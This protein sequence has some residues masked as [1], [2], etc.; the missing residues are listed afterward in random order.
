MNMW[1]AGVNWWGGN[2]TLTQ[3]RL[4]HRVQDWVRNGSKKM[5]VI[6]MW[7][8]LSSINVT[9]NAWRSV[10]CVGVNCGIDGDWW[11]LMRSG[12]KNNVRVYRT[13]I[14]DAPGSEVTVFEPNELP[15][16]LWKAGKKGRRQPIFFKNCDLWFDLTHWIQSIF[17]VI[18]LSTLA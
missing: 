13:F 5:I 8:S 15:W 14:H 7:L 4:D 3:M 1:N 10:F 6:R 18:L 2:N 12:Y 16:I 17:Q 9:L 11:E